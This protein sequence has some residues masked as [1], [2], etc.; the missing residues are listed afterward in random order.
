MEGACVYKNYNN[1]VILFI[2]KEYIKN[3]IFL[4]VYNNYKLYYVYTTS[5]DLTN[6]L[7]RDSIHILT[8]I[9]FYNNNLH[10]TINI[11]RILLLDALNNYK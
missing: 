3:K 11:W 5:K 4:L 9:P 8:K 1:Q 7:P 2:Y 10:Y 6:I